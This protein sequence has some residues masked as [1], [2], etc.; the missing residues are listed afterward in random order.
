MRG[1]V[2]LWLAGLLVFTVAPASPARAAE[3][4]AVPYDNTIRFTG[5]GWGHGWGMS[6]YGALGQAR[7][8]RSWQ[9]I[10][11]FYYPGT[12]VTSLPSAQR[13][14]RIWITSDNDANTAAV[15]IPGLRLRQLA[16]DGHAA[17][18]YTFRSD[19]DV[20]G[21]RV[22]RNAGG[23]YLEQRDRNNAWHATPAWGL[24]PQAVGWVFE[25]IPTG[26]VELIKPS[27]TQ[28]LRGSVGLTPDGS[29]LRT[30]NALPMESYLRGVVPAEMPATW[31]AAAVRAQSVAARTYATR[32][33]RP[34]SPYD[35]CDTTTCQVYQGVS[36]EHPGAD[37]AITATAH[38]ILTYGGQPIDALFSS[39]NGGHTVDGGQ[40][41][42]PAKP[43]PYDG[44]VQ[45]QTWTMSLTPA[46]ISARVN[47]GTLRA[48]RVEQ[49]DGGGRFGG[50]VERVIIV[51]S[52]RQV[53]LS[54]A[55]F[56]RDMGL[57]SSLVQVTGGLRPG[58]PNHQFWTG[59]GGQAGWIGAP[60]HNEEAV[61]GGSIARMEG[62]DLHQSAGTGAHE[63]HGAIRNKYWAV[64]GP[65][66]L[67][68]A[69]SNEVPGH[70]SGQLV[71]NFA[72]GAIYWGPSTQARWLKGGILSR[73]RSP[74]M[75]QIMGMPTSDEIP[76]P[77]PGT[78]MVTLTNGNFYFSPVT[79]S[80]AVHGSILAKYKAS[81]AAEL[82]GLPTS[83]EMPGHLPGQRMNTFSD[84]AIYWGPSTRAHILIGGILGRYRSAGMAE[85]IGAPTSDEIDGPLPGS[86]MVTFTKGNFYFSPPTGSR[87]VHGAILTRYKQVN[88]PALIGLPISDEMA[89]AVPGSRKSLFVR[90]GIYWRP[91]GARVVSGAGHRTYADLG[92]DRSRL[93]WPIA[94]TTT[95]ATQVSRFEHGV[96]TCTS[97]GC[98]VSYT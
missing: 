31:T 86:R 95:G 80:R 20:T 96:I 1:L 64:A 44:Y 35:L 62:A 52:S 57:R 15:A 38:Q 53:S 45:N 61:A 91:G 75:A 12:T 30:V 4:T 6:Q 24:H 8:G 33:L 66:Q 22:G 17:G 70:V 51:G 81:N 42:L 92:A 60:T 48:I 43:D 89:G 68:L 50:R 3:Q 56:R 47:V 73:Y 85:I 41:Y 98:T 54:G 46:E 76:G 10:M 39:S 69:T 84:G 16:G 7:Q 18:T 78:L 9:Q 21:W 79:G 14:I 5:A 82:I 72:K 36:A 63:V 94:D 77:L 74:G 83:D 29:N 37:A 65:A 40:P 19:P 87:A 97:G 11:A 67:G 59:A 23:W 88:G 93:G 27:G 58:S 2:A 13:Q 25:N 71:S 34:A 90:G 32:R 49:R 28:R 55:E 26:Q